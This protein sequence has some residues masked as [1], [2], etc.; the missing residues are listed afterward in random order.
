[1]WYY[2][3]A[4]K[5]TPV[6]TC[7]VAFFA[8]D[9]QTPSHSKPNRFQINTGPPMS[10]IPALRE[11]IREGGVR[12]LYRGALPEITGERVGPQTSKHVL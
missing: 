11:I 7:G 5:A 6:A 1:M 2:V 12:Q 10:I 8:S 9:V 3:V 4:A